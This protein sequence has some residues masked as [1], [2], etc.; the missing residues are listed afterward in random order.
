MISVANNW[1]FRLF[2]SEST[3]NNEQKHGMIYY[4]EEK[5]FTF[6]CVRQRV[7]IFITYV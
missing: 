4:N 7:A 2:S 3:Q 1:A 5:I 6:R